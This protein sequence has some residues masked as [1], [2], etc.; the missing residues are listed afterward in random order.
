M[1]EPTSH[2]ELSVGTRVG[3]LT[4]LTRLPGSKWKCKCDCGNQTVVKASHL[5]DGHTKSCGCLKS[6]DLTGR[7]F[8][9]LTVIERAP[10]Y[11]KGKSQHRRWR[12]RCDCGSE[13]I[14]MASVLLRGDA[15]SCGCN[16]ATI[17]AGAH[18]TH[19]GSNTL[20]YRRWR[21]MIGRCADTSKKH[22]SVYLNRGITVC[23][24]WLGQNGFNN[25]RAWALSHDYSPELTIDRIDNDKGYS[26]DN[27]RW[28]S[29]KD[30]HSNTRRNVWLQY[31]GNK[32]LIP[33]LAAFTGIAEETLR[34]RIRYGWS[35]ERAVETPVA[36]NHKKEQEEQ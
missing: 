18:R 31:K 3:K 10:N 9:M 34:S 6:P 14:H 19:G 21:T 25:F 1:M 15:N 32:Y 35:V 28:I 16:K 23:E 27:C 30:Q 13:S 33:Q 26:P 20:L 22:A 36:R 29:E 2:K 11:Q 17:N 24:E 12:C 4:L 7:R 5:K 8:G